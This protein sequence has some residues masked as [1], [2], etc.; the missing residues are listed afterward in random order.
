[1]LPT[2]TYRRLLTFLL[3]VCIVV[4]A[5]PFAP[6]DMIIVIAAMLIAGHAILK[7]KLLLAFL[8]VRPIVDFWRDSVLISYQDHRLNVNAIIAIAFLIWSSCMLIR[9]RK[10]L[11]KAPTAFLFPVSALAIFGSTLY[12]VDPGTTLI[13][14]IKFVN[15]GAFFFLSYLFVKEKSITVKQ[16]ITATMVS[17]VV[18]GVVGLLQWITHTGLATA[19]IRGRV[20]GTFAHP[21]VLAFYLLSLIIVLI[22]WGAS[23]PEYISKK[24]QNFFI[25]L[26]GVLGILLLLTYTRAAWIGLLIFLVIIGIARYNR[27][28]GYVV[29]GITLFYLIFFPVNELLMATTAI[30]LQQIPLI[31]RLTSRNEDADSFAWRMALVR[32]TIPLIQAR[33]LLGY[34]YGTFENVWG[35]NRS[36]THLWDDSAESHNDYLR[37]ALEIGTVGLVLYTLLLIRLLHL[38]ISPHPRIFLFAWMVSFIIL[39]LSDNMLHHTP[40]M[41]LMWSWWGALLA[42][43]P[44]REDRINFLKN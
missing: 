31:G 37:L 22:Y 41:W 35:E 1:M 39:S 38:S 8:I 5:N 15:I 26:F 30:N 14:A 34:G 12:S 20:Y 2:P 21:N 7:E 24:H 23:H 17:G 36:L 28:L 3:F 16:L 40:V 32:E 10:K 9:E 11:T 43:H 33:P 42:T 19:E 27:M 13:E 4:I 25:A 44:A 6:A 29:A 18:P